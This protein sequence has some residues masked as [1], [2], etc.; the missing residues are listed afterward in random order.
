[1]FWKKK[2]KAEKSFD[3]EIDVPVIKSSICTGEQ[4]A[5]FKN[6]NTGYFREIMCIRSRADRE[7]FLSDYGIREEEIRKEW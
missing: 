7:R 2:E 1:M 3:R 4:V 5:G 6:K